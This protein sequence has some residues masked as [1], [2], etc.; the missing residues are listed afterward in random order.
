M[1]SVMLA[2]KSFSE[3]VYTGTEMEGETERR[4]EL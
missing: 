2:E 3:A 4:R 1:M